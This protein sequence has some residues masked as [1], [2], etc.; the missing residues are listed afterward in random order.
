MAPC[1]ADED[2][3]DQVLDVAAQAQIESKF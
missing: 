2:H 1:L 3:A